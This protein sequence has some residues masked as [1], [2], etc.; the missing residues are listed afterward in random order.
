MSPVVGRSV[1][2][3]HIRL[4]QQMGTEIRSEKRMMLNSDSLYI[5][6]LILRTGAASVAHQFS[7][8]EN[9]NHLHRFPLPCSFL[10]LSFLAQWLCEE[11]VRQST[12][13]QCTC[14]CPTSI[15]IWYDSHKEYACFSSFR[16]DYTRGEPGIAQRGQT[17]PCPY[18]ASTRWLQWRSQQE[19]GAIQER[20]IRP[21]CA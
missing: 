11:Q 20:S 4:V 13:D 21:P 19:A 3:M 12:N 2:I 5:P 10:G 15:A 8:P 16:R 7:G 1:Q 9:G 14:V 18:P 17:R 6:H